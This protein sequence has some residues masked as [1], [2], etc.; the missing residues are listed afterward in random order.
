M[1]TLSILL[2][3]LLLVGYGCGKAVKNGGDGEDSV[4]NASPSDREFINPIMTSR[5][6]ELTVYEDENLT[7]PL[8]KVRAGEFFSTGDRIWDDKGKRW[9]A[10]VEDPN[11][12]TGYVDLAKTVEVRVVCPDKLNVRAEPSTNSRVLTVAER[13]DP[14]VFVFESEYLSNPIYEGEHCWRQA[15]VNGVEGYLAEE[16]VIEKRFFDVLEPA[17][18]KYE[19]GDTAGMERYLDDISGNH[20]GVEYSL[21]PDGNTAA[22]TFKRSREDDAETM[23]LVGSPDQAIYAYGILNHCF[24]PG[25]EYTYI[26]YIPETYGA[27]YFYTYP[28]SVINNR[29]GDST[30]SAATYPYSFA[31]DASRDTSPM[32]REFVDDRYLLLVVYS[33]PPSEKEKYYNR[34]FPYLALVDLTTGKTVRLLKPDMGTIDDD[35]GSVNFGVK[36]KRTSACD[37]SSEPVKRAMET[38]LFK[39]CD[40]KVVYGFITEV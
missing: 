28:I 15:R 24:S 34:G 8:G 5:A 2:T 13:G 33:E 21:A 4:I 23:Y 29:T 6:E 32:N 9:I 40:G 3:T 25:G 27:G 11:V 30:Y 20:S 1:R 17:I 31:A 7:K 22:V 16:Y 37:P 35:T 14:V 26:H 36:L 12:P 38:D 18:E 19:S 10:K 39:S